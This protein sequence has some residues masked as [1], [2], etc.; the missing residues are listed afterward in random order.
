MLEEPKAGMAG[1]PYRVWLQGLQ[2]QMVQGLLGH[3]EE[4]GFQFKHLE[5]FKPTSNLI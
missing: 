2:G 1:A 3:H 5:S 4:F